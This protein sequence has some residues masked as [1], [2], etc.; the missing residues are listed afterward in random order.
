MGDR[1]N[2]AYPRRYIT[3]RSVAKSA[4]VSEERMR[5]QPLG[6]SAVVRLVCENV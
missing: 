6:D 3:L 2:A 4:A 1:R 5:G